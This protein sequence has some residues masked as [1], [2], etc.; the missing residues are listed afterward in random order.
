M[1]AALMVTLALMAPAHVDYVVDGDT[2]RLE[3]G[4]YVRL[5]GI[6]TP[7]T[8]QC[9]YQAAKSKLA[10]MV[11]HNGMTVLLR[12]PPSVDDAD[13][14]GRLLRYVDL[15]DKDTGAVLIRKGL[16]DARYDSLDGYDH[17]PRQEKYRAL[18]A[19]HPDVCP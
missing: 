7:E 6:D 9:G 12:N 10:R 2:V 1:F 14:Y 18:D 11:A 19:S 15:P 17:H 13:R 4:A 5:I 3:N 8:G 16:A